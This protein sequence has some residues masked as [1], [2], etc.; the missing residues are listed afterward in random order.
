[1]HLLELMSE[2]MWSESHGRVDP[3][4]VHVDQPLFQVRHMRVVQ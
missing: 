3:Y 1:M 4:L 2:V